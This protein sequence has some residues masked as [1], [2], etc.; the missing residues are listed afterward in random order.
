MI[1]RILGK[2]Q[3]NADIGLS[4]AMDPRRKH[5]RSPEV[6]APSSISKENHDNEVAHMGNDRTIGY[7]PIPEVT[8]DQSSST[9]TKDHPLENI[10]G[11]LDRPVSTRLQIHEQALFCYYDAFLTSVEPKSYKDA[12]TQA[13]WIEAMQEELHEFERLKVWELVPPPNKAFVITLK[14]IYK[15]KLDKLGDPNDFSKGSVILTVQSVSRQRTT[16]VQIYGDGIIFAAS[17]PIFVYTMLL[18][19]EMYYQ[20]HK[21]YGFESC[22]PVDTLMVEKSKLD[23]DKEGKVVDPSHYRGTVHWGLWY[24]KDSSIA[25]TAFADA[26]H[27]GCQDTRH[28]TSG[29]IQLL[30]DRLVSW[31]SKRQKALRYLV[32]KLNILL[33]PVVVLKSFG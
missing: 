5:S 2:L 26:D 13:C 12:L 25:L 15:V 33:Y 19:S 32:Q 9:D 20:D 3:P 17:T 4:L 23:E 24:P 14:W 11:D 31:S 22:D 16:T 30:S 6:I 18:K 7:S 1:A 29:S 27:V 28:S 21:K 8:S 10:I